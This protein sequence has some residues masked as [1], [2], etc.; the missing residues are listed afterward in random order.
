[1]HACRLVSLHLHAFYLTPE[2]LRRIAAHLPRLEQLT[3]SCCTGRQQGPVAVGAGVGVG[4]G[5]G[6]AAAAVGAVGQQGVLGG[7]A[8]GAVP[9]AGDAQNVST[10]AIMHPGLTW[11]CSNL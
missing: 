10:I 11:T 2:T 1:M 9:A 4:G 5:G 6:A 7:L 3:L 8:A